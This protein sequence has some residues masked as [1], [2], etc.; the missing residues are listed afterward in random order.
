VRSFVTR[1]LADAD[2]AGLTIDDVIT[3]LSEHRRSADR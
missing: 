3:A 1:V 2:R